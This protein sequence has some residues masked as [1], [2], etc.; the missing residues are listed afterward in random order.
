MVLKLKYKVNK[1]KEA[2]IIYLIGTFIFFLIPLF[3]IYENWDVI[4][5]V[6]IILLFIWPLY[7]IP[8]CF[9]FAGVYHLK[10]NTIDYLR[11]E[12]NKL[13]IHKGF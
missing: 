13:S 10:L 5:H 9:L 3:V 12:N 11:F 6:K 7:L 8:I 4:G 2:G 1:S